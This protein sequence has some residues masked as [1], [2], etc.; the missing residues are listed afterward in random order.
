MP[1]CLLSTSGVATYGKD[2]K[3]TGLD[4]SGTSGDVMVWCNNAQYKY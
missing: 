4:F 3:G 2:R 1:K